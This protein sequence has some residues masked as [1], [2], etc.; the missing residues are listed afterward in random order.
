LIPF[1]LYGT[2]Y[3]FSAKF[4]IGFGVIVFLWIWLS[5]AICA[6]MPLWGSRKDMEYI[7]GAKYREVMRE[8]THQAE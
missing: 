1:T 8:K 4:F 6:F 7:L 3:N 2:G 5:C